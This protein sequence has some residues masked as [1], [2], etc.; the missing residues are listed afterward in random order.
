MKTGIITKPSAWLSSVSG[1]GHTDE[2][3]MGWAVG[4]LKEEGEWMQVVTHYGYRGCLKKEG[5]EVGNAKDLQK[6]EQTEKMLVITKAFT[7]V[8]EE[9]DVRSRTLCTLHRGSF[10]SALPKSENGYRRIRLPD[11]TEGYIPAVSCKDR[12]DGDG[13]L[14]EEDPDTYFLR[15]RSDRIFTEE[16]FRRQVILS[17]KSY[18]GTQYRWAG[19]SAEGIDCSGL[20][21]MSYLMNGILIYRDS[22]RNHA[23]PVHE[24]PPERMKPGDL[25]YFPGHIAMYLGEKEYIHAARREDSFGCTVNSLSPKAWNYREDLAKSLLAAGSIW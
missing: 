1:G 11:Q 15:Q 16:V 9:A 17:A 20:V 19:K 5:V 21:F 18:L 8:M 7:D 22:E 23:Y 10:V 3:F 4:I 6:R 12:K 14:Y 25:L 13:Y 24:I 2:L